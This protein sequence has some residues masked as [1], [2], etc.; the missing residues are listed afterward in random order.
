MMKLLFLWL[1]VVAE[2]HVYTCPKRYQYVYT[3]VPS[4][5]V[6]H[7]VE[8]DLLFE[9]PFLSSLFVWMSRRLGGQVMRSVADQGCGTPPSPTKWSRSRIGL[10]G[11]TPPPLPTLRNGSN[12]QETSKKPQRVAHT[13]SSPNLT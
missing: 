7:C 8:V 3:V 13:A 11:G 12:P 4:A 6:F 5:K 9:V 1:F 10:G 2:G